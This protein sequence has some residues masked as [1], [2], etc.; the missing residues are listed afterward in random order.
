[1]PAPSCRTPAATVSRRAR[2]AINQP[3]RGD[4][5]VD[6]ECSFRIRSVQWS[7]CLFAR[8]KNDRWVSSPFH[9][10][11]KENSWWGEV[12]KALVPPSSS[13]RLVPPRMDASALHLDCP[14]RTR[15][16]RAELSLDVRHYCTHLQ[17]SSPAPASGVTVVCLP[18]PPVSATSPSTPSH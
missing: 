12:F 13:R 14:A 10:A 18:S 4:I 1:L 3:R 15:P 16:I 6:R 8:T 11:S 2:P 9:A 17:Y 5:L 7:L